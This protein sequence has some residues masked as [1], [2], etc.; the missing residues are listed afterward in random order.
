MSFAAEV[1]TESWGM[2]LATGPWLLVGFLAA[3][4]IHAL[5]PVETMVRQLS[6]GGLASVVK[7]A[8]VGIPLPLCSCGVIPVASSL[9]KHGASKGATAAFL[10]ST[11]ETG[12]DSIAVTYALLG[13]V[14]AVVRPVAAL[15]TTLLAGGLIHWL[16]SD[17]TESVPDRVV[18]KQRSTSAVGASES[19]CGCPIDSCDADGQLQVRQKFVT[20][21]RYGSVEV[22]ADLSHW[23]ILGFVLGGVLSA[24]L[25]DGFL[26]R[27]VGS[28][29]R[30]MLVMVVVGVPMYVCATSSTPVAAALIARGL[31]PGAGLVF[32]LVGP[33]TNLATLLV[34]VR[35]LGIRSAVIYL[36][37]IS[38]VAVACGLATDAIW[39]SWAVPAV[40]WSGGHSEGSALSVVSAVLLV[41]LMMNGLRVRFAAPVLSRVRG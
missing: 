21:L 5:V 12:V 14:M 27:Q 4:V 39:S 32:L 3:G 23:L 26:E 10:I 20:A 7:A 11:P 9:R 41:L 31:S 22:F 37:S 40:R 13:P 16:D 28:G 29:V 18:A 15:L 17:P 36:L 30:A 38:V 19:E 34:V 1:F 6:G 35:D 24:M 2:L 33:A 8:L 25:P